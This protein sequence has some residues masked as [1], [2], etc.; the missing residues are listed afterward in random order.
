M[1]VFYRV[2]FFGI[3]C[4]FLFTSCHKSGCTNKDAINYDVTSDEDDGT[5]IVCQTTEEE[6]ASKVLYLKD[7]KFGSPHYNQK[8]AKFYLNQYVMATNN[9]VCG[10]ESCK[11]NLS[12]ESMVNQKMYLSY[13][14][15]RY[16][17]PINIYYNN[18]III[19][20]YQK[21]DIGTIFTFNN[22]PFLEITL[23]SLNAETTTDIIYF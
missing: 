3:I 17:G 18:D 7:F 21:V 5:C 15:E 10:K 20:A 16:S 19:D 9:A 14:I 11:V 12:I 4:S 23:D 6:I 22:P 8:V 13:R 2:I 1:N